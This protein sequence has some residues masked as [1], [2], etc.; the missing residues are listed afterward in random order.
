MQNVQ[1]RL[2]ARLDAVRLFIFL[3]VW[4]QQSHFTL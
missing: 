1:Q 2:I 3:I 4:T